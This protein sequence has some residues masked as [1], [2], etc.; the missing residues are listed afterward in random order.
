MLSLIQM[1]PHRP[2]IMFTELVV[3]LGQVI[4][5][6]HQSS[7]NRKNILIGRGGIAI[8]LVTQYDIECLH[9]IESHISEL[10]YIFPGCL[11]I[12]IIL[13]KKLEE[14][15]VSEN[16]ALKHINLITITRREVELVCEVWCAR[17]CHDNGVFFNNRN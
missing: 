15:P 11:N 4:K 5:Q 12:Y 2:K 8:T 6:L 14:Y 3:P 16:K 1:F 9:N 7:F 17:C 10:P 13:E